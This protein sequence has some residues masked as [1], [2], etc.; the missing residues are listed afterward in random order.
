MVTEGPSSFPLRL[1][2]PHQAHTWMGGVGL[3]IGSKE[4][5]L[6]VTGDYGTHPAACF[7]VVQVHED[8]R[9]LIGALGMDSFPFSCVHEFLGEAVAIVDVVPAAAPQ[10]VPRQVLGASSAAA[11]TGRQLAF[12][13][14]SAH[15]IHHPSSTHCICEGRLSAACGQG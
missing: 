9:A 15:G 10:P 4:G 1:P 11:A 13:A 5:L 12:P 6:V 2:L 14:G 8:A 3:E 7:I